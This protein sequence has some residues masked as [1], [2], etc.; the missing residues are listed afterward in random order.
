M[1]TEAD[2]QAR[3]RVLLDALY[4]KYYWTLVRLLSRQKIGTDAVADI[5]QETFCRMHQVSDFEALEFPKAYLFR[6][7]FNLARDHQ[8]QERLQRPS[9]RIDIESLEFESDAPNAD[10]IVNGKQELEVV[11]QALT[12]LSPKCRRA[13]VR[14]RFEN[15]SYQA[16]AQELDISVSMIEKYI[17][18]ALAH[19]KACVDRARPAVSSVHTAKE[20]Q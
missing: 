17:S 19:I 2:G 14:N 15:A 16:I 13:F 10:R 12:E 20:E 4:R 3:K 5:V 9:D 7:A 8:R 1:I 11:R 6:T 18:Q